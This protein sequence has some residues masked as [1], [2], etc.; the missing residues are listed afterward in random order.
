MNENRV[1]L[2]VPLRPGV[3]MTLIYPHDLT[4]EEFDFFAYILDRYKPK[5]T[6]PPKAEAEP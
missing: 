2:S 6:V 5:I 3:E 1:Q 4:S